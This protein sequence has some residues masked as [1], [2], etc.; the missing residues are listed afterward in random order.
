MSKPDWLEED[1]LKR[2][3]V[4]LERIAVALE[5]SPMV[6][7]QFEEVAASAGHSRDTL[8]L[9]RFVNGDDT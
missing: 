7:H 2:I 5:T 3:E 4:L 6:K 8:K 1:R 9:I